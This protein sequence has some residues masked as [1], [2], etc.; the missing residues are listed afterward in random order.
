VKED[1]ALGRNHSLLGRKAF[2]V[3]SANR[4]AEI[5]IASVYERDE[6]IRWKEIAD[7]VRAGKEW[8]IIP[9]RVLRNVV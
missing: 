8:M 1:E 7:E 3:G 5:A 9:N 4:L 6:L 2:R